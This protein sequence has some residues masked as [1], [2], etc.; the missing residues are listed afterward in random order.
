MSVLLLRWRGWWL[1]LFRPPHRRRIFTSGVRPPS[2]R[3]AARDGGAT[4]ALDAF[5][6]DSA[7][8][9]DTSAPAAVVEAPLDADAQAFMATLALETRE[10]STRPPFPLARDPVRARTLEALEDLRQIPALQSLAQEFVQ[11]LGRPEVAVTEVVA[12]IEKDSALCVRVLRMANSV[13]IS[14]EQRI[15]D[16]DTA[17]QMLGVRRVRQVAQALFTLRGASRVAEGFDWRHLWVHALATAAIAEELEEK[18]RGSGNSQIYLAAL[19]HD[20]GKIVLSTLAP[21]EYRE[22]L[23]AAWNENGRLEELERDRLGVDHREAGAIFG[24]RNELPEIVLAAIAHHN[25]PTR[26]EAH[27]FEVA[28][29][30]LANYLSKAHGLGFSGARLDE[31]DGDF[32][33][34]AAWQ[35][36]S[37]QLGRLPDVEE[38]LV[39][40]QAFILSLRTDL[41][42]VREG[43]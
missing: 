17:V 36:I 8:A 15:E 10:S 1:R 13:L 39:E 25:E 34:H 4:E 9:R 35:V 3:H 5:P 33:T 42:T 30:A 26:A 6:A 18:L 32:E 12:T 28:V 43:L 40:M 24:R 31:S 16:L 2:N 20:V 7:G 37:A 27:A 21:D 22:V 41:A 11:K 23:V 38:L 29:I 19:L 14:P